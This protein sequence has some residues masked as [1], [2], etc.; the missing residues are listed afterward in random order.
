MNSQINSKLMYALIILAIITNSIGLWLP[1]L[2]NDDPTLYANIAKHIV[3]SGD[4]INLISNHYDWLDKPHFPFWVTALSFKIFGINSFAYVLP[5]FL[6]N[7]LGAYYT[8]K[9][10]CYLY[11]KSTGLLAV[12]IYLTALH[13]MISSVDVRAE[14]YLLGTIIPAAYYWLLYD[15]KCVIRYLFLGALFSAMAIMTKGIFV[16]I[17]IISGMLGLWIY[18]GQWRK[19]FAIKWWGALFL[20]LLFIL[21]ELISLYL[22][23]DMHPEKSLFG[24]SSVSGVRFFFW[25]SQFGRFFN[26]GPITNTH[27][28]V[29]FFIHTFLWAF[30][31]WSL[32]FIG[33]LIASYKL[34]RKKHSFVTVVARSVG[35][36]FSGKSQI[37]Y[38]LSAFFPTFILFSLTKFQL[39][40]YTNILMPFAA[41]LSANYLYSLYKLQHTV[42]NSLIYK[43]QI[44]LSYLLL[45]LVIGISFFAFNGVAQLAIFILAGICIIIFFKGNALNSIT[46]SVIYPSIT[47]CVVYVFMSLVNGV[48]YA[49]YDAGYQ[50]A[51]YLNKQTTLPIIDYKVDSLS[52]EFH[53]KDPYRRLDSLEQIVNYPS[54]F[55]L[56]AK[57]TDVTILQERLPNS[58]I[59]Y[60]I[61]GATIDKVMANLLHPN[62]LHDELTDY[63]VIY[64]SL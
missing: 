53:T 21:P 2:R 28:D 45:A 10:A 9:L 47:I 32:V 6:F 37:V 18:S 59:I 52:L 60:R 64:S 16:L 42:N 25:D 11:D 31:P 63:V 35:N 57:T 36:D 61:S 17:T 40:H 51:K 22:Q 58:K 38:L 50:I 30:L 39:D 26:S 13:L 19:I 56:I 48:I 62:K 1:I 4:W 14:S 12:L 27:G 54:P 33:A 43:F 49:N 15:E 8:Y 23:F 41:I 5:G 20:T 44:W 24:E 55:Y 46:K 7:L 29:F 3:Q 34:F